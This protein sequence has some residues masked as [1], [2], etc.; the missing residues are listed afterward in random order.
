MSKII[1]YVTFLLVLFCIYKMST[2]IITT[3][4]LQWFLS[5]LLIGHFGNKLGVQVETFK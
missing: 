1:F 2:Y 3:D 5:G 4:L